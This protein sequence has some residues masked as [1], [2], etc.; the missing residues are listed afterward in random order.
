MH[1]GSSGEKSKTEAMYCPARDMPFK[2]GGIFA[3]VLDCGGAASFTTSFVYLGSHL[4]CD[5]PDDYNTDVRIKKA[6]KHLA[7]ASSA[8]LSYP[9]G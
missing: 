3:L 5:L 2:D 8:L 7:T 1:V 9:N 6:S 4:H